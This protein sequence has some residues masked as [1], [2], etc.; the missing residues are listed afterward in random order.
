MYVFL[1]WSCKAQLPTNTE[2]S[3]IKVG[4]EG[5]ENS[6]DEYVLE[7]SCGVNLFQSRNI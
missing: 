3:S 2:F 7:G 6:Q 5:Y 4:C 1:Q